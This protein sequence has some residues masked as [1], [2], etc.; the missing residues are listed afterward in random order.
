MATLK[1]VGRTP[2]SDST[3]VPKSYADA[4]QAAL[5]VT[6]TIVNG[7]IA[8]GAVNLTSQSYVDNQDNFYAHKTDV[9]AADNLAVAATALG[10]AN[11][12]ASLDSSGNLTSSQLPTSGVTTDRVMQCYSIGQSGGTLPLLGGVLN[13]VTGAVGSILLAS[14]STHTVTTTNVR[15]FKLASIVIPDPGYVWRPMPFAWVQ[16]NTSGGSNPGGRSG[17][18]GNYGLLTCLPPS[19]VSDVVYGAGVCTAA[20]VTD[21]Y[22]L[23]PFALANQTHTSVPAISG[24]I[25]LDLYCSCFS[26]TSYIFS[27]T[28]L[29]YYVMVVPSV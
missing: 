20:L 10:A 24:G 13:T 4:Q 18:N 2:D 23:T 25:T 11:G 27:G 28:N 9:T 26:G 16:G 1:Y 3:I 5:S 21:T 14:G 8:G 19:G 7:I 22:L 6:T 29:V 15:E 17:G 12:V